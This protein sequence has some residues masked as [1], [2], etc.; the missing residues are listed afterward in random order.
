MADRGPASY[1]VSLGKEL[2]ALRER[3]KLPRDEVVETL[4]WDHTK[5]SRVEAGKRV[6]KVAEIDRLLD[7]YGADEDTAESV[8]EIAAHA[9][10]RGS[11]G[12]V[13]DWARSYLGLEPDAVDLQLYYGEIFP[14]LFQ[15][16]DYARALV[17]T[18]LAVAPADVDQV[19]E[20]RM[21]RQTLLTRANPPVVHLVLGESALRY[22]VG[23]H[24]VMADQIDQLIDLAALPH[25]TVQ[26]ATFEAGAH[27][28]LGTNFILLSADTSGERTEWA[29]SERLD[30]AE[31][32]PA[33]RPV[34]LYRHTFRSLMVNAASEAETLA[35]L[36]SSRDDHHARAQHDT[37]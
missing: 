3:A 10:K 35:L 24:E 15:R 9:R 31:F 14:G 8:R 12:R 26:V 25:I 36:R 27:A 11:Y 6:P 21:K 30:G 16:E 20:A 28:S 5:M 32:T 23:G 17:S 22:A 37:E 7:L 33:G 2:Q 19:V 1:R 34:G 13:P 4:G 29:Y 18:S